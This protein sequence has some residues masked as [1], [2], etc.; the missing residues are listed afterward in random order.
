[1]VFSA[2]PYPVVAFWADEDV[3]KYSPLLQ[4]C[5]AVSKI[6]IASG[7]PP[8]EIKSEVYSC[9][10]N[11]G[12][13]DGEEQ[14]WCMKPLVWPPYLVE[15]Q[16]I[17]G[18]LKPDRQSGRSVVRGRILRSLPW[19]KGSKDLNQHRDER[20]SRTRSWHFLM[21][22]SLIFSRQADDSFSPEII[23]D[24]HRRQ[25]CRKGLL[26]SFQSHQ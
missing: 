5:L 18:F 6:F 26:D 24:R 2:P 11:S 21:R 8:A 23:W 14:Y 17:E 12:L 22:L 13:G 16:Y 7:L 10:I 19:V 1:M 20:W 25:H 9:H 3:K 15:P 4:E